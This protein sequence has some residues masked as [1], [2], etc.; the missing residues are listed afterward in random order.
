MIVFFWG[1]ACE[2]E[3]KRWVKIL[4]SYRKT[5]EQVVNLDKSMIFFSSNVERGVQEAIKGVF[6]IHRGMEGGNYLGLSSLIGKSKRQV[7]SYIKERV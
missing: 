7:L 6:G 2:L 3:S 5:F 1:H 4:D